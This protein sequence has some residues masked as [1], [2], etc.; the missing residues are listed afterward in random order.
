M[1][2]KEKLTLDRAI[3]NIKSN[4]YKISLVI[5]GFLLTSW[6]LISLS[7]HRVMHIDTATRMGQ[8]LFFGAFWCLVWCVRNK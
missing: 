1:E 5:A 7:E 4:R 6:L 3:E 2:Q 8:G